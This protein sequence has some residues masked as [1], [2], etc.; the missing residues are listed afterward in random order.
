MVETFTAYTAFLKTF[1]AIAQVVTF[2]DVPSPNG[3][4]DPHRVTGL[5]RKASCTTLVPLTS[6]K[7]SGRR[8]SRVLAIR[9]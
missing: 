5:F 9:F 6:H 2:D 7:P 1:G 4:S 3:H 8:R